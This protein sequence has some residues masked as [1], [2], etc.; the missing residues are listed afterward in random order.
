MAVLSYTGFGIGSGLTPFTNQADPDY[1]AVAA[2]NFSF[3]SPPLISLN[4]GALSVT[5]TPVPEPG[6]GLAAAVA[7]LVLARRRRHPASTVG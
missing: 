4:S 6:L 5:F 2:E 3:A 7:G 1:F